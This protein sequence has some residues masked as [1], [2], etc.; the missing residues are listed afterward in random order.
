MD[1][2]TQLHKEEKLVATKPEKNVE[3]LLCAWDFRAEK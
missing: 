1:R 3:C 2:I